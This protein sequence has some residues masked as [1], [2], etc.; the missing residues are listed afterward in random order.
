MFL[1][2]G[3]IHSKPFRLSLGPDN[4]KT[5]TP[6]NSTTYRYGLGAGSG[7]RTGE[8]LEGAAV[9]VVLLRLRRSVMAR[10]AMENLHR[11]WLR[12][13]ISD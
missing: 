13:S 2:G 12:I 6:N 7:G 10:K 8:S 9:M 11:P 4:G 1:S 3:K 5:P